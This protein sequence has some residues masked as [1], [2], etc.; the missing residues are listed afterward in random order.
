MNARNQLDVVDY[1]SDIIWEMNLIFNIHENF[2][3]DENGDLQKYKMY[4][5]EKNM[6]LKG[7]K[8]H[9]LMK[10]GPSNY[11]DNKLII[12]T[13]DK[14][15]KINYVPTETGFILLQNEI[16][17][18]IIKRIDV[19][20]LYNAQ[21]NVTGDKLFYT[22]L[23]KN[24]VEEKY[25]NT[26]NQYDVH[27]VNKTELQKKYSSLILNGY[28]NNNFSLTS[29]GV[30]LA[31][32]L[33][34]YGNDKWKKD[35][36][37]MFQYYNVLSNYAF[38]SSK[39]YSQIFKKFNEYQ[40]NSNP[41]IINK[42]GYKRWID[43]ITKEKYMFRKIEALSNNIIQKRIL[44]DIVNNIGKYKISNRD[45]DREN[46]DYKRSIHVYNE[47]TQKYEK[48]KNRDYN[49]NISVGSIDFLQE[50]ELITVD[51]CGNVKPTD[52]CN[53]IIE[54]NILENIK[55]SSNLKHNHDFDDYY[56][57]KI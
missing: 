24:I 38:D 11:I 6:D 36:P 55:M 44:M 32:R 13:T 54:Q 12:P 47:E 1:Q 30:H 39:N 50:R 41:A 35:F 49:R 3:K 40:T 33:K 16:M 31:L 53:F 4:L 46:T 45:T 18:E 14:S 52:L 8:N 17:K 22:D 20:K 27:S 9:F 25:I 51:R 56:I 15:G 34:S 43:I 2:D 21:N 7:F 29:K 10:R 57:R 37:L 48:Q 42:E 28:M 19:V 5:I 26:K 23:G